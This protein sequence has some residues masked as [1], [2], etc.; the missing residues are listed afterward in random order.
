MDY[1]L[2]SNCSEFEF[3]SIGTGKVSNSMC[4]PRGRPKGSR[5]KMP[6]RTR[7]LQDLSQFESPSCLPSSVGS[8]GR[9]AQMILQ[10]QS[11]TSFSDSGELSESFSE[12]LLE[13]HSAS[14]E[15]HSQA[16]L[17]SNQFVYKHCRNQQVQVQYQSPTSTGSK[18]KCGQSARKDEFKDPFHDDWP[19]W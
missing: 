1:L 3:S 16:D 19:H 4:R 17:A 6:R 11:P 18:S 12:S 8:Q 15:I 10:I 2:D 13:N 7:R 14:S 5:D 9:F